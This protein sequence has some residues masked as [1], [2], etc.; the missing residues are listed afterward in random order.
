MRPPLILSRSSALSAVSIGLRV[1]ASAMPV[2]SLSRLLAI[3]TAASV[4]NGGECNCGDHTPSSSSSSKRAVTLASSSA[5]IACRI[6]QYLRFIICLPALT[7]ARAGA[8]R[9]REHRK[10]SR[11]GEAHLVARYDCVEHAMR[12]QK[13]G[14]LK[15]RGQLD[16]AGLRSDPAARETD[17]CA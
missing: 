17:Q 9:S 13:L 4:A 3:A 15:I 8:A 12:E 1:N 16:V 14:A 7:F 10:D 2:P 6:S 5:G 11:Q